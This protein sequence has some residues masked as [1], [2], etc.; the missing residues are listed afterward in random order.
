MK[1]VR[2]QNNQGVAGT[3]SMQGG[4]NAAERLEGQSG[5]NCSSPGFLQRHAV[6]NLLQ[7]AHRQDA[8]GIQ[9][10]EGNVETQ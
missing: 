6:R 1:K 9:E 4:E 10:R 2:F 7:E 5:E 3:C 8:D